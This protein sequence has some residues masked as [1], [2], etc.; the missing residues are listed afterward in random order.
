MRWISHI[1]FVQES[2]NKGK[3]KKDKKQKKKKIYYKKRAYIRSFLW[4]LFYY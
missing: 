4:L 3:K 2:N 1:K